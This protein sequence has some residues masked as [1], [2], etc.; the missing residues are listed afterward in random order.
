MGDF[1]QIELEEEKCLGITDC[2]ICTKVCPVNIFKAGESKPIIVSDNEDECTLCNL[3]LEEC[4]PN[5]IHII[6]KY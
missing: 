1:I 3:C 4:K 6:K 2:G 5:V